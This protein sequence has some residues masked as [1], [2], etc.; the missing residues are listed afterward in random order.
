MCDVHNKWESSGLHCNSDCTFPLITAMMYHI[1]DLLEEPQM[2]FL[3][4]LLLLSAKLSLER[5]WVTMNAKEQKTIWTKQQKK[6]ESLIHQLWI[7]YGVSFLRTAA[8]S[9]FNYWV[10]KR[11]SFNDSFYSN[12]S[13][14]FV[15]S[16][17]YEEMG[18]IK[19]MSK[20]F[21]NTLMHYP[22]LSLQRTSI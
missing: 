22:M 8:V 4:P 17:N 15:F 6:A 7:N 16:C 20:H 11:V 21:P 12:S 3:Q 9:L 5:N 1:Y 13:K 14:T 19:G 10:L 18:L 2:W